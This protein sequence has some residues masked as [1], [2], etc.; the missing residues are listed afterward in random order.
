MKTIAVTCAI[1]IHNGKILITKR[2]DKMDLAGFWEF[3]GGKVEPDELAEEC[4]KREILEELHIKVE[5]G[6]RLSSSRFQISQEKVIELMPFLCSWIS[7]EI[8]LTEHEEV[9]WVNI[10]ELESFQWAP[11]D[12][13][14]YKEVLVKWP[15]KD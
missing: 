10:G 4:L 8:K 12:I 2:S 11:A 6:T 14:I 7:G 15:F 1:I 5:V 3:P 9:R 13:P